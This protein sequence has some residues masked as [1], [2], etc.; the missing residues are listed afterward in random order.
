MRM[1]PTIPN[2]KGSQPNPEADPWEAERRIIA[3]LRE[4]KIDDADEIVPQQ[5]GLLAERISQFKRRCVT[6]PDM[7][8]MT[9]AGRALRE[10]R[11]QLDLAAEILRDEVHRWRDISSMGE[12]VRRW[13]EAIVVLRMPRGAHDNPRDWLHLHSKKTGPAIQASTY[14]AVEIAGYLIHVL[15]AYGIKVSL[16]PEG[17]VTKFTRKALIFIGTNKI[18]TLKKLSERLIENLGAMVTCKR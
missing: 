4:C 5:L 3:I 8:E 15:N 2:P 14:M 7:A 10:Q 16:Q 11:K 13:N 9:R 18:P 1:I 17:G 6:E 12:H